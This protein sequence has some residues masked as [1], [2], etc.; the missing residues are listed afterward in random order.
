M[1]YTLEQWKKFHTEIEAYENGENIEYYGDLSRSWICAMPTPE[2]RVNTKYRIK[3]K[4]TREE[5]TANWVAENKLKVG[6]K[7]KVLKGFGD[8]KFRICKGRSDECIGGVFIVSFI[9]EKSILFDAEGKFNWEFPVE[10]LEKV[11]EE[12]IPFTFEDRELFKGKWV[13]GKNSTWEVVINFINDEKIGIDG[14][15]YTYQDFF[16]K[17]EFLDKTPCG[18]LKQ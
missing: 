11:V 13:K 18:K 12:W 1:R 6:D 5:I 9:G 10:C 7:V 14:C 15:Y 3:L 2:F 16:D 17:Y 8:F 4:P